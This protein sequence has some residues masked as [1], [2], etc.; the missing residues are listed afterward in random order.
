MLLIELYTLNTNQLPL[1]LIRKLPKVQSLKRWYR[2]PLD[3]PRNNW[4]KLYA[5][6]LSQ[7]LNAM[8]K[9]PNN[10]YLRKKMLFGPMLQEFS[11]HRQLTP[12]LWAKGD[13]EHHGDTASWRKY[14]PFM[15]GRETG[16]AGRC[17]REDA[18]FQCTPPVTCLLQPQHSASI[19]TQS[20]HLKW[21]GLIKSY[22][23]IQ[24]FHLW[25]S[26]Y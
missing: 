11:I 19:T 22:L 1:F 23:T 18:P 8:T 16:K 15:T 10:N 14:A 12:W 4:P 2:E 5:G 21:D 17:H 20:L 7:L 24:S 13:L 26:Q 3:L 25:I 6:C 9:T